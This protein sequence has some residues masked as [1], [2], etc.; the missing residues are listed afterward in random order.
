MRAVEQ[1]YGLRA[2]HEFVPSIDDFVPTPWNSLATHGAVEESCAD[3]GGCG[4]GALS[5]RDLA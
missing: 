1:P 3:F 5:A 2:A 4:F